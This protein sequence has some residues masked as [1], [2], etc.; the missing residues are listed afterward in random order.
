MGPTFPPSYPLP[1]HPQPLVQLLLSVSTLHTRLR[2]HQP[3]PVPPPPPQT[4]GLPSRM[5]GFWRHRRRVADAVAVFRAA[6]AMEAPGGVERRRPRAAV[7]HLLPDDGWKRKC[8]V[9]LVAGE[10]YHALERWPVQQFRRRDTVSAGN[11][12]GGNRATRRKCLR[13]H[14]LRGF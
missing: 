7:L 13:R 12:V 1:S 14:H 5:A 3:A 9:V 10:D 4:A 11:H 2:R 8:G 6:L